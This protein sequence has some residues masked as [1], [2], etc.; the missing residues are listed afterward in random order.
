MDMYASCTFYMVFCRST[1]LE[2]S[3][4]KYVISVIMPLHTFPWNFPWNFSSFARY[5]LNSAK[6]TM[7]VISLLVA[8]L[9]WHQIKIKINNYKLHFM[10]LNLLYDIYNCPHDRDIWDQLSYILTY[11]I[12]RLSLTTYREN[13]FQIARKMP[14]SKSHPFYL[15]GPCSEVSPFNEKHTYWMKICMDDAMV[16]TW[17]LHIL[18]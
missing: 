16:I 5:K 4:H 2:R 1:K 14:G 8:L 18:G 12:H 9:L 6:F 7:E 10:M 11:A 15:H 3:I 17:S 13:V